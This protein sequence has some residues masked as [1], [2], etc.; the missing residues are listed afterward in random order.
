MPPRAKITREMIVERAFD[1]LREQGSEQLNTRAIAERLN[2]STQPIMYQ[3]A[4]IDELKKALY[5]RCN[6]FHA[7]YLMQVVKSGADFMLE[8][9]L[10]YIRFAIQEANVFKFLFQS[11][12]AEENSFSEMLDTPEIAPLLEAARQHLKLG[13]KACRELFITLALFVH[14][15]ASIIANNALEYD[16]KTIKK[17]LEHAYKG[18]LAAAKT[19]P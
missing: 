11:G 1:L 3:F 18:A 12:Y 5:A 7:A 19:E 10:N 6:S 8:L 14:G 16:E 4:K 2:C 9:G 15:Y 13:E 17:H